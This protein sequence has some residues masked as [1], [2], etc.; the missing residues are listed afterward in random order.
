M[1]S[2]CKGHIAQILV[3]TFINFDID[4][5]RKIHKVT[6]WTTEH[7]QNNYCTEK[8]ES[9]RRRHKSNGNKISVDGCYQTSLNSRQLTH[10][11]T[12]FHAAWREAVMARTNTSQ[13]YTSAVGG[14]DREDWVRLQYPLVQAS[15]SGNA[16]FMMW[17]LSIMCELLFPVAVDAAL[18]LPTYLQHKP[19]RHPS[20]HVTHLAAPLETL[21]MGSHNGLMSE[22]KCPSHHHDPNWFP[23]M[24]L[25]IR[26]KW[27]GGMEQ[28][29]CMLALLVLGWVTIW[30]ATNQPGQLSLEF[31]RG[32]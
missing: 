5:K 16:F 26:C 24:S 7:R 6:L 21:P 30:Y 12:R 15:Y 4:T 14:N 2:E 23:P 18:N 11:C 29:Y 13:R 19:H 32:H 31:L 10:K 8:W 22:L 1:K 27:I 25:L 28:N 9:S 17:E 20:I 3:N